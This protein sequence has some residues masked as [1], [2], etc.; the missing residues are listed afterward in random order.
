[1]EGEG[2]RTGSEG[3]Q[4]QVAIYGEAASRTSMKVTGLDINSLLLWEEA[5][6]RSHLWV[7]VAGEGNVL[8]CICRGSQSGSRG[9][10]TYRPSRE[11]ISKK[12]QCFHQ[13]IQI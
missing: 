12:S 11:E 9:G 1:M 10:F 5:V 8:R 6:F 4:G 7:D 13:H 3:M 2:D